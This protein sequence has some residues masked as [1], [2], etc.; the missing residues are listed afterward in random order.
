M[1]QWLFLFHRRN[2]VKIA[3]GTTRR[4]LIRPDASRFRAWRR[5]RIPCSPGRTCRTSHISMIA[6]SLGTKT[7]DAA[8]TS[9]S[10]RSSVPTLLSF[11]TPADRRLRD[12]Y[13]WWRPSRLPEAHTIKNARRESN[14]NEVIRRLISRRDSG[15]FELAGAAF[16]YLNRRA[17]AFVVAQKAR[18]L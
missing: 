10:S 3:R 1:A 15:Q 16:F 2:Y 5:E 12:G 9:S 7:P 13:R 18:I 4:K 8:S 17:T 6:L 11:R 14:K